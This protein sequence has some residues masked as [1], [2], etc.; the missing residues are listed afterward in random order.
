VLRIEPIGNEWYVKDDSLQ[1]D[2]QLLYEAYILEW[3]FR[4][5]AHRHFMVSASVGREFDRRYELTLLDDSI[6]G[7]TGDAST[8]IGLGLAWIF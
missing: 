2:S 8:R 5:R 4:W 6:V 7:L 1:K 3:A